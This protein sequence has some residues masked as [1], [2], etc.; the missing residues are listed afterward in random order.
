M[1]YEFLTSPM[2][3][4][5]AARF[6]DHLNNTWWRVQIMKLLVMQLYTPFL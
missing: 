6:I 2:S 4:I 5:R 3:A 1:M